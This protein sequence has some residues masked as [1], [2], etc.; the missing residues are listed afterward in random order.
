MDSGLIQAWA[1]VIALALT[2]IGL[3]GGGIW[4]MSAL[5]SR[6]GFIATKVAQ[7]NGQ[8]RKVRRTLARHQRG[9]DLFRHETNGTLQD[10]EIRLS[11]VEAGRPIPVERVREGLPPSDR[12]V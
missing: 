4:W 12:G 7:T 5:Y 2:V 9:S 8:V 11:G 3:L 6:V 10:H 1:A